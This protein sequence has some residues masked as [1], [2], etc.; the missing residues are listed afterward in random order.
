MR[1]KP[2]LGGK[3]TLRLFLKGGDGLAHSLLSIAEGGQYL[4]RGVRDLVYEE[5]GGSFNLE[6]V[7]EPW[8]HCE[9]LLQQ[10]EGISSPQRR[11]PPELVGDIVTAQFQS[12]LFEEDVDVV[13]LSI[14]AEITQSLWEHRQERYLFCPPPDWEHKWLPAQR[15]WLQDHFSP[16]GR[17]TV[18]RFKQNFRR[19]VQ[20]LKERLDAH[21]IV[22]GVSSYDPDDL[23]HNYHGTSETLSER[24]LHFNLALSEI[25]ALEG[26]S[27]VDVDRLI[28]ELGGKG[29]VIKALQ[30]SMHAYQEI[31]RE[32][33]RVVEDIGFFEKRPL[34]RQIGQGR[35]QN[36][37]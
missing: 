23:V 11:C 33:L 17:L 4:D 19:L 37:I 2:K 6:I 1:Q 31:C 10:L 16:W 13:V 3:Q 7:R 24:I 30:Y 8:G 15:G 5:Y 32:F 22:F 25:S 34:L 28:A 14:Q 21:L 36:V 29:H 18:K 26:I 12:R 35:N 20:I 9:L 27:I